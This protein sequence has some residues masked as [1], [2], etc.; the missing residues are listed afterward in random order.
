MQG[1]DYWWVETARLE[2]ACAVTTLSW[3]NEGN[4]LITAGD[5]IQIWHCKSS[6]G[7]QAEGETSH[8][9]IWILKF[10]NCS[11]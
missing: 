7:Q 5:F 6:D 2:C 3:N 8:S 10:I 1:L 9:S 4:R 11:L